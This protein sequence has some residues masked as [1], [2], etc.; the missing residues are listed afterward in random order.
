M[1]MAYQV[2]K[3]IKVYHIV[4]MDR[5]ESIL[6]DGCLYSDD[7]INDRENKGITIGMKKIKH[8]RLT[9]NK[10]NSYPDLFVGQ[11]VPFYFCPRSVMLYL[12]YKGNHAEIDYQGGQE[13]IIHL[14]ADFYDGVQWAKQ[15]NKRWVFTLSNAASC[16]FEDRNDLSNLNE[17]NW[18]VVSNRYWHAQCESKQA[19]FLVEH[20]F[21]WQLVTRIGVYSSAIQQEVQRVVER[22]AQKVKVD[23]KRDWYY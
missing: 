8:R 9:Q 1:V 22:Y 11:C 19:E 12:I 20:S 21:A 23:I 17:V 16:W 3:H 13:R 10:L 5:L 18:P 4:H 15:N 6:K 14:E 7:I 2:P